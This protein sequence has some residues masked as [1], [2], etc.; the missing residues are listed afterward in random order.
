MIENRPQDKCHYC[1]MPGDYT[2]LVG[3]DPDY[4]MSLVCKDHVVIGL[5]S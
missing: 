5:V 2:Q 3:E 4:F 1:D